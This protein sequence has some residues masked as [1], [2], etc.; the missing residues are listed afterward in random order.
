M[1]LIKNKLIVFGKSKMILFKNDK[2]IN[3]EFDGK[4]LKSNIALDYEVVYF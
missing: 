1:L 2:E 3:I 4:E